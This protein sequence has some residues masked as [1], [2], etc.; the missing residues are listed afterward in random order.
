MLCVYHNL[1]FINSRKNFLC[2]SHF[3]EFVSFFAF[4]AHSSWRF[5]L[6]LYWPTLIGHTSNGLPNVALC[7]CHL[8]WI[9]GCRYSAKHCQ[10][11]SSKR[12]ADVSWQILKDG[13]YLSY[14]VIEAQLPSFMFSSLL[15]LF[16]KPLI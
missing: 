7:H 2:I 8:H 9:S 5:P 13:H 3:S 15:V 14:G 4:Q 10:P 12:K 16:F 6:S 11:D 1:R